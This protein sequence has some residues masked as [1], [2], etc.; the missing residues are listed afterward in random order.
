MKGQMGHRD[1]WERVVESARRG[2]ILTIM[3]I[4]T[5]AEVFCRGIAQKMLYGVDVIEEWR[6]MN[7]TELLKGVVEALSDLELKEVIQKDREGR[8]L[9]IF[10]DVFGVRN[11]WAWR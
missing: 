1:L 2:S 4:E 9:K 8:Y 10:S 5:K 6:G 3:S 11:L 7:C